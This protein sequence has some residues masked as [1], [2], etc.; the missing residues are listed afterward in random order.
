MDIQ[1]HGKAVRV[2]RKSFK[3]KRSR[4]TK[5]CVLVPVPT[6][7]LDRIVYQHTFES[8]GSSSSQHTRSTA[9]L[10]SNHLP[11]PGLIARGQVNGFLR[12]SATNGCWV[13]ANPSPP[14]LTNTVGTSH[15]LNGPLGASLCLLLPELAKAGVCLFS[16]NDFGESS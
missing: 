13:T 4:C 5:K 6:H 11:V 3:H 15:S 14:S 10:L 2:K 16:I 7:L 1:T 9:A 8:A 12:F